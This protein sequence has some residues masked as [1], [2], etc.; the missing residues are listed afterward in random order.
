MKIFFEISIAFAVGFVLGMVLVNRIRKK[1]LAEQRK[2]TDK[3]SDFYQLLSHW[4]EMKNLGGSTVTYFEEMNY[5]KIAI[6]GMGEI[7]NRLSEELENSDI[8]VAYGIDREICSS[9]A[10]IEEVYSVADELP[11]VD[12]I[13]VTP[14][15]AMGAIKKALEEKVS[16]PIIS[17]EEVVW[18]V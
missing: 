7:A 2:V 4:V 8:E 6:Y 10:R 12:V 13:V 5:R 17:I 15:Y 1:Q 11:G 14:F 16:C 3:F 9:P 18:S